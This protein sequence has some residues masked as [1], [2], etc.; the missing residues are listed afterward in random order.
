MPIKKT[1]KTKI[2]LWTKNWALHTKKPFTFYKTTTSTNDE[3]KTHPLPYNTHPPATAYLNH[4]FIA[5]SQSKGR[6]QHT[7]KWINSD[8]ML[9]WKFHLPTPALAQTPMLLAK[10]LCETLNTS[11]QVNVFN[12]KAPNDIVCNNK[13]IA[14]ILVEAISLAPN[15]FLIIGCGLNVF[16][17]P[18]K[19]YS[20]QKCLSKTIMKSQWFD[21]LNNWYNNLT[22]IVKN[23]V[24]K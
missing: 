23:K 17:Y 7:R 9:S 13:K 20:L 11:F 18:L 8:M 5:Q 15:Y 6:G 19:F 21:F 14:G 24:I 1:Q 4:L 16:H 10:S 2:A 3:A 12:V 22:F